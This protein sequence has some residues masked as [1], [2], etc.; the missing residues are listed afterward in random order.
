MN[1]KPWILLLACLWAAAVGAAEVPSADAGRAVIEDTVA[2]LRG[3]L[4]ADPAL[5]SG[6]RPDEVAR[7]V[8]EHVLPH[9]DEKTSGRMI[10]GR[11][12][13]QATPAQRQRFI[14]GYRDLLLRTY[15][16]HAT[17][18]LNADV[19]ILSTAPVGTSGRMLQVRT[20]VTRPGKPV[21]SVD[22]RMVARGG[23]WKV[24]DAVVQGIS[25]VSTLR[26]AVAQEIQRYGIDGLNERLAAKVQDANLAP[27]V[28]QPN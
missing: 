4:A 15:A 28:P 22:Y 10:L 8:E 5:A 6:E 27:P 21:S 23:E 14:D 20:R 17:D 7:L 12:W 24:F 11:Y 1:S 13:R 2:S 25:L 19:E 16:V 18:Y 9:V 26:N 3:A